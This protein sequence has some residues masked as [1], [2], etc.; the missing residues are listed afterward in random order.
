MSLTKG[1]KLR[2]LAVTSAQ[3]FGQLPDVPTVAEQGYAGYELSQWHGLLAPSNTPLAIQQKLYD[4]IN[5]ALQ[6]PA[7]KDK[8]NSLGYTPANDD[9]ANFKKILDSDIDK[10]VKLAKEIKL[11]V[12]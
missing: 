6:L 4:G 3:R 8:L 2:A 9:P 10:F 1:G 5:K 7:V 12:D 11:K